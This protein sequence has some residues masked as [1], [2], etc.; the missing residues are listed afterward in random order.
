M[1]DKDR[2]E[3]IEAIEREGRKMRRDKKYAHKVYMELRIMTPKGNLT[4]HW[5][6]IKK[7]YGIVPG[8]YM[9][10]R[11]ALGLS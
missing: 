9:A 10:I 5:Q 3:M 2:Q 1:D 11:R 8:H 4:K 7:Q 6:Q